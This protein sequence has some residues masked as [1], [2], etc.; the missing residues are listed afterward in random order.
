MF[1][2]PEVVTPLPA[3]PEPKWRIPVGPSTFIAMVGAV[4]LALEAWLTFRKRW[5]T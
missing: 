5:A 1:T 2:S 4:L 3:A